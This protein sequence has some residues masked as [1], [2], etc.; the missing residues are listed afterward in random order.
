VTLA[1]TPATDVFDEARGMTTPLPTALPVRV[2]VPVEETPPKTLAGLR[3]TEERAAGVRTIGATRVNPEYVA[4]MATADRTETPNVVIV[5]RLRRC[6]CGHGHARR[7]GGQRRVRAGQCD[8]DAASRPR[9]V[10]RDGS[11]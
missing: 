6:S 4:E 8:R 10:Q 11:G 2:T 9:P 5:K 1:G 7:N 3:V